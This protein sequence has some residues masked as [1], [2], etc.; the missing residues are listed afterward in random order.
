MVVAP[1]DVA[2]AELVEAA[3]LELEPH[4]PRLPSKTAA[5]TADPA[6][7]PTLPTL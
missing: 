5:R 7:T 1:D 2:P 4:A 6:R 3:C